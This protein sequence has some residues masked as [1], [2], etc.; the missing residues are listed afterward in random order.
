MNL[1]KT[2]EFKNYEQIT[3]YSNNNSRKNQGK[4]NDYRI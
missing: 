1:R 4:Q 2:H 3:F